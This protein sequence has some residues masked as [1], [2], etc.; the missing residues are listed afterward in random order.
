M[1]TS[2]GEPDL[3]LVEFIRERIPDALQ[4]YLDRAVAATEAGTRLAAFRAACAV[5]P[6]DPRGLLGLADAHQSMGQLDEAVEAAMAARTRLP[7]QPESWLELGRLLINLERPGEAEATYRRAM[8]LGGGVDARLGVGRALL[9]QGQYREAADALRVMTPGQEESWSPELFMAEGMCQAAQGNN[10]EALRL[11][12]KTPVPDRTDVHLTLVRLLRW[13]GELDEAAGEASQLLRRNPNFV[14]AMV[15][16]ARLELDAG[17]LDDARSLCVRALDQD[18]DELSAHVVLA[19]LAEHR[20]Q[21]QLALNHRIQAAAAG[22]KRSLAALGRTV[23]ECAGS[24]TS[25]PPVLPTVKDRL[26]LV[27]VPTGSFVMGAPADEAREAVIAAIRAGVD[28]SQAL[29]NFANAPQH[30]VLLTHPLLMSAAPVTQ[31]QWRQVMGGANPSRFPGAG[32]DAPVEQVSWYD[33]VKFCNLLSAEAGMPRQEWAYEIKGEQGECGEQGYRFQTVRWWGPL[34]EGYRLPTEAEWEYTCRAGDPR[35]TY[36]GAVTY[37][38]ARDAPELD[39]IAWYGGNSEAHYPDAHDS[40]GWPQKQLPHQRAGT[41][42]VMQ[43]RPNA[44]GLYDMLG[45]VWEWC[46]DAA[47]AYP[48]GQVIDPGVPRGAAVD[49]GENR[50]VRG[51]AWNA[52]AYNMHAALRGFRPPGLGSRGLGFRIVCPGGALAK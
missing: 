5:A 20:G 23:L 33:A 27:H 29:G 36:N 42:P 13:Q 44:W 14:P 38:G 4:Y 26:L 39:P 11:L 6:D 22:D 43:K 12:R 45:N 2:S 17:R 40:S 19:D 51:G 49:A 7:D 48:D 52:H 31:R 8:E 34:R 25:P 41:Q 32:P 24:D 9:Q 10:N 21:L 3:R 50:V 30:E 18:P 16:S 1:S 46:W 15:E 35:A 28:R 47:A 37:V